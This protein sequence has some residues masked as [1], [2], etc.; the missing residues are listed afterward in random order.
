[1]TAI[2]PSLPGL[3]WS[4]RK[5]P[6]FAT[7]VQ[8]SV[9]GRT[10]RLLDQ[11]APVWNFT[12]TWDFLRDSHDVRGGPGPGT[13]YDELRTLMGFFLAQQGRFQPFLFDDPSD[14]SVTGQAIGTGDGSTRAFQL[15]R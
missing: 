9:S 11:P 3:A 12:L 5:S 1:M 8:R 2:F 13:G 7:R 6:H 4:V 10:L 14:D 15:V